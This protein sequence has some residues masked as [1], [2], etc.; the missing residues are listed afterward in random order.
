[1]MPS[2]TPEPQADESA[3]DL[4]R[5]GRHRIYA[6]P[7]ET[8]ERQIRDQLQ[9][10]LGKHGFDHETDIQAIKSSDSHAPCITLC[11][12]SDWQ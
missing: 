7:F 5:I 9:A 10:L 3:R 2:P 1:M 12:L 11:G 4:F 6:T 8:H